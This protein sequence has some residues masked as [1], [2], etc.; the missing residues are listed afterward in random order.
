MLPYDIGVKEGSDPEVTREQ[1]REDRLNAA[2][3]KEH[4]ALQREA[5]NSSSSSSSSSSTSSS[6]SSSSTSAVRSPDPDP[7]GDGPTPAPLLGALHSSNTAANDSQGG[8]AA[9]VTANSSD[10]IQH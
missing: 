4:E 6:T 5:A 7:L 1:R 3:D 10:S 9:S 8:S 2:A